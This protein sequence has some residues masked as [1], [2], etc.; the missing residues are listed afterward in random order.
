MR[1]LSNEEELL[2]LGVLKSNRR[3]GVAKNFLLKLKEIL[4]KKYFFRIFLEVRVENNAAI[5]F[6][7]LIGFKN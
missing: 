4:L 7:K 2:S 1:S 6:Y 5:C 3:N